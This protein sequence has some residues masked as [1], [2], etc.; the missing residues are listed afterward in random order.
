[1]KLY[2]QTIFLIQSNGK[3]NELFLM[4]MLPVSEEFI[5]QF[6]KYLISLQIDNV[7]NVYANGIN[8]IVNVF[9]Y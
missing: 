6:L 2:Y 3:I 4:R 8:S 1:M 5:A 9:S 7:N